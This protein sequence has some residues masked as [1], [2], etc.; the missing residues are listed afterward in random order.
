M[1]RLLTTSSGS[2]WPELMTVYN[3]AT[4][5]SEPVLLTHVT[6]T[7]NVYDG[8]IDRRPGSHIGQDFAALENDG[9]F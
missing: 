8:D 4:F 9:G 6:P 1:K 2:P 7:G 3:P 5:R